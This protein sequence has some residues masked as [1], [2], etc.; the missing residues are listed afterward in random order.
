MPKSLR[1]RILEW[2]HDQLMHPGITRMIKTIRQHF[3]WPKLDNDV[4]KIC[5]SCRTCQLT[6]KTKKKYGHLPPKEAEAI[7]WDTL[8]IDL[9]GPYTVKEHGKKKWLLHCLTMIDPATGW[10]EIVE[11]PSKR[12]D[13]IA[14]CLEKTWFARYPWPAHVIHDRGSEF[15]AEVHDM[16]KNDYGCTVNLITTRNP[17]ANAIVERVHQT[18]G[19]MIRTWFVDDPDLDESDPFSGLLAAIAFATRATVHTTLNATP[20]QLVFGRDAMLNAEFNADWEMIR[21]RKQKKINLNNMMEN[22]KRIPHQYQIGDKI[23]VKGDANRKFGSNAYA[24]PYRV[25]SVRNNGTLRYQKGN[26]YDTI[27]IRNVTPYHKPD[28]QI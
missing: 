17:Q 24:G 26:I 3:T 20:S 28:A 11:I 15:M 12:A 6:K 8:C 9:I 22:K 13:D 16:I 18:I 23:L 25:T 19:N 14:N 4:E 27:N 5:K 21:L 7:P 10:F 2:Y 1:K